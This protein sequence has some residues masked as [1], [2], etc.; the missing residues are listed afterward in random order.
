MTI[1]MSGTFL[2]QVGI[3]LK[4]IEWGTKIEVVNLIPKTTYS[5]LLIA[6]K[7]S[8]YRFGCIPSCH[9]TYLNII[10]CAQTGGEK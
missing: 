9:I 3:V 1:E 10:L 7:R 6:R 8:A 4:R 2:C 5:Y